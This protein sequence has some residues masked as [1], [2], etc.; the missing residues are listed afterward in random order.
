MRKVLVSGIA[1]V[2]ILGAALG[3]A[4][5]IIASRGQPEQVDSAPPRT[6]VRTFTVQPAD[7]T[8]TI[9]GYGQVVARRRAELAAEVGG[10]VIWRHPELEV[11]QPVREGIELVKIDRASY[12]QAVHGATGA[13]AATR[14]EKSELEVSSRRELLDDTS[15]A[16]ARRVSS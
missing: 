13:L 14:A 1:V 4:S 11:G 16:A 3:L 2:L 9:H 15:I 8:E 12:E 5:A 10:K 6:H 7:V